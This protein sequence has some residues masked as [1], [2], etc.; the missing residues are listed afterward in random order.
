MKLRT[1]AAMLALALSAGT[2]AAQPAPALKDQIVG[3][4]N[5]VVAEVNASD[6]KK[7]FPVRRGH[8]IWAFWIFTPDGHFL[9]RSMLSPPTC[10]R[11]RPT[12]A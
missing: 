3:T 10:P 4:W 7:S 1:I 5:F 11:S 9:P 2:A 12:T 6:G 8:P